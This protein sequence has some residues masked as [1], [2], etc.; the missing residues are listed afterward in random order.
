MLLLLGGCGGGSPFD[1]LRATLDKFPEYSVVLEDMRSQG[2]VAND[3]FHRY[4]LIHPQNGTRGKD[5]NS[6]A[7]TQEVTDWMKIDQ[8]FYEKMQPYLGMVILAKKADG[9][10]DDTPQPPGFQ[11]VGDSRFG[12]WVAD[13][14]GNQSWE[15]LAAGM[16]LS[17]V[18]DEVGD[19]F[20]KKHK[21]RIDHRD[22][23][24]YKSSTGKK[25]PYFG[26]K[27][28]SGKPQYG[29]E[30]VVTQKSN[31]G[32]FERQQA[33]MEDRKNTF[34]QKVESRMGRSKP[35]SSSGSGFSLGG[36]KPSASSSSGMSLGKTFGRKRR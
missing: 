21:R 17:E 14:Q 30:G 33:R 29:T 32:F 28:S 8:G 9:S 34:S 6:P 26:R 10:I 15:W 1:T 4:R 36:S 2:L 27:D 18:V 22:W 25:T 31:K 3:Y 19:F 7:L 20:E 12:Q 13:A 11:F 16:V 23:Q 35:S 24:A 5:G